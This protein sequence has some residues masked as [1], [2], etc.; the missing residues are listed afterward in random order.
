[1][2]KEKG[3][4]VISADEAYKDKIFKEQPDYAGESL[5]WALAKQSGKFKN[6]LRY[7]AEDSRYEKD[8]MDELGL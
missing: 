7:P 8:K 2:F 3:W 6:I 1:M 4:E 5:V